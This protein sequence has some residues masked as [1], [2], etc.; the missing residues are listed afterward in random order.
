MSFDLDFLCKQ[1]FLRNYSMSFR[2]FFN[3]VLVLALTLTVF[4][5]TTWN[6]SSGTWS[7]GS[8]WT[9]G[10]P[11]SS[12]GYI[13]I[14]YGSSS[15]CRLNTNEG[16][17]AARLV[18]QDGQT[19]NIENG[20]L[21]GTAWSRVGRENSAYVNQSGN[22]TFVMNDDDLYI[23]LEGGTCVW[24]MDDTSSLYVAAATAGGDEL[25]LGKDGGNGKLKL[26]GS[27]VTVNVD[28]LYLGV[29]SS[30]DRATVEYV[31]DS[32][33]A[34]AVVTA[35]LSIAPYGQAHLVISSQSA[36]PA[37]DIVLIENTSASAIAG[38]GVFDTANSSDASQ[39]AYVDV[40]GYRYSLTYQYDAN[41]DSADNDVALL[42]V[43]T[44]PCATD[45]SPQAGDQT[46]SNSTILSWTS[47]LGAARNE[48][49]LGTDRT[50]VT[51]AAKPAG[52]VDGDGIVDL[53]DFTAMASQWLL[54]PVAP[55]PDLSGNG[56]VD[57][58]DFSI[59]SADW[60]D[61][62]DDVYLGPTVASQFAPG[63][64]E[65]GLT[66]YW[67][68]D[69][70][71]CDG[72]EPSPVWSFQTKLPA[73]PGADGFGK[74]ATG[75]RGGSVYHVT[76][77]NASGA[78]S[79]RDAVSSPN[80]TV[81]FDVGGII[82]ISDRFSV[83][84]NVTIAGQT[85]PGEGIMVYGNGMG[86]T[87]S[88]QS[89]T[90]YMRYRMGIDGTS[91]K[92]AVGIS[93]GT[94][95]IFDHC[96][97]SWGR[98]E[99]FSINPDTGA[100]L[101]LITI[102]DC[103]IGQG[104]L[105]HSA[106]G[107]IVDWDLG[108]S[109][110]RSLYIDNNTRNPKVRGKNEFINNVVYNW[111]TAAYIMAWTSSTDYYSYVNAVN[112]YFISGPNMD[113]TPP[114]RYGNSA[115]HIYHS[116][117]WWDYDKDGVLDGR[118]LVDSDY[119]AN[120]ETVEPEPF[121]YPSVGNLLEP[122]VAVKSIGS[123]CGV[124]FPSRDRTDRRL[125]DELLSYGT[126]GEHISNENS[127]PMYGVGTI[128]NGHNPVDTDQDGMPDYWE[129]SLAGL[130]K[131][132]ADNNAD[133]N[134]NGY[135]DLEDYINFLAVPHD[136]VQKNR[137]VYIDLR[138]RAEG[139]DSSRTFSVS[140]PVHGT[141]GLLLDGFRACFTPDTDYVGMAQ[142]DFTV[143][144][145]DVKNQT[146]LLNVSEYGGDPIQAPAPVPSGL[147]NGLRYYYYKGT[148]QYLPD[149]STLAVADSGIV[150][151]L[152]ITGAPDADS[153]A[154]EFYGYIDIPTD[155]LYTFFTNSDDGSRLYIDDCV[156]VSNDGIHEATLEYG[157][158]SLL[159]GMH[160]IRVTYFENSGGQ[161]F[162]A[163]WRG[164]GIER[165]PVP[166]SLLYYGNPLI[167]ENEPGF[168]SVDG[169]VDSNNSGFTGTGFANT[170]N[171]AGSGVDW[172]VTVPSSGTY[173][174]V[175]RYAN[176]GDSDRPG[177]LKVNSSTAVSSVSFP[178]TGGWSH[179]DTVSQPVTLSAGSNAIRIESINSTGLGNFDY[180][181]IL[182]LN[183]FPER[184][185]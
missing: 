164:P 152:D 22:G 174:L 94:N 120:N 86:Y 157:R 48:V 75:G 158:I 125:I 20:G 168:C 115:F 73:F 57:V 124:S 71:Y 70:V 181:E 149:F 97:I 135:T 49:Y 150:S 58:P 182:D 31:L 3:V 65:P 108:I 68:V 9:G 175:F 41:A 95:M 166:A 131:T 112:N 24:T 1:S 161:S 56:I 61:E 50:E 18:V 40:A 46:E 80:R 21:V 51:N 156:V 114:F 7:N 84:R 100:E 183:V 138:F 119:T 87:N 172:N 16:L 91:D 180:L 118:V 90:R 4:A 137:P 38:N 60:Q 107:L 52:D 10:V 12:D 110:L 76:N 154:Y 127:S 30:S 177:I 160:K 6:T 165:Q 83:S 92:D 74:W 184:C 151:N 45:P 29:S 144:D 142:F 129:D 136:H 102:Q 43:G 64:L 79:F 88:D 134:A 39:G 99:N 103:I 130:D 153:F 5:D 72:I 15:V 121:D 35:G 47:P 53:E 162:V 11:D 98:D 54:G 155:G 63:A 77:L 66:Y 171:A 169:T 93:D 143:D 163:R 2:G 42:Y 27:D 167:Q 82:R 8:N 17:F 176:G 170:D 148:W 116:N 178:S 37:A 106:G 104:L 139:F 23:G 117:N 109:I 19:L 85:A 179:W 113:N 44:T 81:V 89:I 105:S 96:S 28:A 101:G 14:R 173:T 59:V 133:Y 32:S 26:I 36:P 122:R 33:G 13:N 132:V 55:C 67:R 159:A 78:G 123:S 185:Q 145:G 146:I 147:T 62:A 69:S 126:M 34:S 25:Y 128:E 140:N 111:D 141:V